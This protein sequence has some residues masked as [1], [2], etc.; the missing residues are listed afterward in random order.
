VSAETASG[1]VVDTGPIDVAPPKLSKWG[2]LVSIALSGGVSMGA[3]VVWARVLG[4]LLGGTVYVF[5]TILAVFLT[6][7]GIGAALG[8][9]LGRRM[10][11]REALGWSQLLAALGL[12]WTA[13]QFSSSLPFWPIFPNDKTTI[14]VM[15]QADLVRVIWAIL[16]ATV[17]WGASVPL[18]F[19]AV[20]ATS[21]DAGKTVGGV[22]AANTLGCI[23]GALLTSLVLIPQVGTHAAERILLA[24]SLIAA[25]CAFAP[26]VMGTKAVRGWAGLALGAVASV[27]LIPTLKP[28]APEV[29]AYGRR[30]TEWLGQYEVLEHK[31]GINTS[32]AYTRWASGEVQFHVAGKVEASTFPFDMKLQRLLGY[33]PFLVKPEPK[34]VLIVGFGAGVTAGTFVTYP[35][36]K[37]IVICEIEPLIPESSTT[38]FREQ[39]HNVINDPRTQIYFDDARHYVL[40]TDE[41]FD[42]I[43]SDPIHPFVKGLAT[44]YSRE[45]FERLR[46]R[47]NKGGVVTQW[48]PLYESDL[49]TVKSE[50]AT[51]MEAFP[52]A[53]VFANLQSGGGYDLV[54]LGH[55]EPMVLDI[56]GSEARLA[57]PQ[58]APMATSM[59]EVGIE[60][61]QGLLNTYIGDKRS[62]AS[63]VKDAQINRDK[64]L[65]LQY[66]AGFA[67]NRT[68]GDA[69]YQEMAAFKAPP[70]G[71]RMVTGFPA[72]VAPPT[73]LPTD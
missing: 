63:W 53:E 8:S 2:V 23:F 40:T 34:S 29:V 31:E 5:S 33:V 43:T 6:G 39:N 49:A 32:I 69:I 58:Y 17:C 21:T 3:Q 20:R 24:V 65:R 64:D 71:L 45:Y 16:P 54:L 28:V 36:V 59:T 35:S 52:Y 41:K 42:L 14:L 4:P 15:L 60:G 27:S 10:N 50:V 37:R 48:I 46:K 55:E 26:S 1:P 68:Q 38:Y 47:L 25:F 12:A 7:L 22:Y 11:P 61:P 13:W 57:L 9:S 18:A 73:A 30:S 66:L 70:A 62:L 51:F 67:L 19:A 44:L 56:P 72:R